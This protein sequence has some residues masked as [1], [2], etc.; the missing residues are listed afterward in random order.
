LE[1][2]QKLPLTFQTQ[3]QF[4]AS[5]LVSYVVTIKIQAKV[6]KKPICPHKRQHLG[7]L[8][9]IKKVPNTKVDSHI[10]LGLV[11]IDGIDQNR[12]ITSHPYTTRIPIFSN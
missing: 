4:H 8:S 1:V 12:S 7:I 6:I 11:H 3:H 2:D 10:L 5:S 9:L